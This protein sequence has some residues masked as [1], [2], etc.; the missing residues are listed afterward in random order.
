MAGDRSGALAYAWRA[1]GEEHE[2]V[3]VPVPGTDEDGPLT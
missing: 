3:L 2:L 1:G